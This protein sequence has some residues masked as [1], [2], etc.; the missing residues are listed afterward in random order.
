MSGLTL[1]WCA[2]RE[3]HCYGLHFHIIAEVK[4]H[5]FI[6]I[7]FDIAIIYWFYFQNTSIKYEKK[8]ECY[9]SAV[10]TLLY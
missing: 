3:E 9:S 4:M 8:V 7:I 6:P 10:Y 1:N 2:I 5:S